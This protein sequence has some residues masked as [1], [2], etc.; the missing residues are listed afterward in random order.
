MCRSRSY[1]YMEVSR[2]SNYRCMPCVKDKM[3]IIFPDDSDMD[4]M[5]E[6]VVVSDK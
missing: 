5:I 6:V 1:V 2:F 3:S 4:D